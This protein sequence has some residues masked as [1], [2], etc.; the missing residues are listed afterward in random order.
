M[1]FNIN[2]FNSNYFLLLYR[3]KD[4]NTQVLL[5]Y[6][7]IS[8]SDILLLLLMLGVFSLEKDFLA[9]SLSLLISEFL[10]FVFLFSKFCIRNYKHGNDNSFKVDLQTSLLYKVFFILI[11]ISLI[12]IS[13]KYFLSYLGEGQITYYTYGL[14][15]PLMIRQSLD[16]RSN[17]FVQINKAKSFSQTKTI[18]FNTIKKLIPFF[19]IGVILLVGSLEIL[20][21][22]I[23]KVFKIEDIDLFKNIIYLGILITPLY[24]I[25]DLFYRFYYREDQINKLL[26]LVILGLVINVLLNYSLGIHLTWGIYGILI[27]TLIVFL[28]YNLLSFKYFFIRNKE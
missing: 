21:T 12:D 16:I 13:D 10:V 19:L 11:V 27:S 5:Y 2:T 9:I 23:Y 1:I 18:F 6:L 15:T 8:V 14:Y 7:L 20:E 28:F 24:M 17:F 25:W 26:V 3:Y 4:F 22:T